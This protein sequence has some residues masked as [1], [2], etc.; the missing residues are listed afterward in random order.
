M[1]NVQLIL[2]ALVAVDFTVVDSVVD[3]YVLDYIGFQQCT[4]D[5][6]DTGNIPITGDAK[7]TLVMKYFHVLPNI[8]I[9]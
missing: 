5:L 6:R 4:A 7:L 3:Y 2:N 9:K 1:L 8:K